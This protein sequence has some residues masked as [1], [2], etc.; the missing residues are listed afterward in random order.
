MTIY[1]YS[2]VNS[3]FTCPAQFEFRYVK[4]EKPPVADGIEL[5]LGSRFHEVME[6]LYRQIPQRIPT[7]NELL[8]TFKKH[9]ENHWQQA[10]QKQKERNL[11]E[12][13]RIVHAGQT[14]EDFF[15]KGLLFL[16][17]YYHQYHPFDQ[18][19]TEG[20]ELR[21][22]FDLDDKGQYK[23]QGFIDRL[24]RDDDGTLWIHDYKTSSRKMSVEDARN[25][26]QLALY[27]L[28]LAQNPKYGVKEKIKLIW[29]FVAFENDRVVGER[30]PKEI[31]W[32]KKKYI[33]KI[34]TIEEAKS[35]PTKPGVLCQWCEYLTLCSQGQDWV[36]SRKKKESKE[37][38]SSL[39]SA[40]SSSLVPPSPQMDPTASRSPAPGP[41]PKAPAPPSKGRKPSIPKISPDQL[42][43]FK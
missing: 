18:D 19:K 20:I 34:R 30:N 4:K 38:A 13:L 35:Y 3:Y 17:N 32:L 15:K 1:S 8:E 22:A 26:D 7:V 6:H 16:E 27:Q 40:A 5:F 39:P 24:G 14:V 28:G 2:R 37:T 43:L 36:K 33:T 29:H 11:P 23:M 31:E 10:L 9:W 42:S 25:E 41:S 12:P 21:V